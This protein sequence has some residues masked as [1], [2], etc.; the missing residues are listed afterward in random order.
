MNRLTKLGGK[1]NHKQTYKKP[2]GK[3][4]V[5]VAVVVDGLFEDKMLACTK[6]ASLACRG[7]LSIHTVRSDIIIASLS[8]NTVCAGSNAS[9]FFALLTVFSILTE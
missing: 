1:S 5:G 6:N 4:K 3:V 7:H 9:F 8:M 2:E